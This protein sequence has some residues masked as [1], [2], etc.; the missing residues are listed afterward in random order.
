MPVRKNSTAITIIISPISRIIILIPVCPKRFIS[1]EELI[2]TV[3]VTSSISK[4][5]A[6]KTTLSNIVFASSISTIALV[7][8][9][10]PHSIGIANGVIATSFIV[11]FISESLA[12]IGDKRALSISKPTTKK[13]A[14]PTIR[15]LFTEIPNTRKRNCPEKA[16]T[17][18]IINV[19]IT[20]RFAMASLSFE[21]IS[22]VSPKKTGIALIGL[23]NVKKDVKTSNPYVS[24]SFIIFSAKI[25]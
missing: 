21:S 7:I 15:K 2:R 25:Y 9:P 13:I 11:C 16:N 1:F 22:E 24:I 8:A 5:D 19:T 14:P 3:Y 12:L 23:I 17:N 20:A 10:G 6:T 18:N 4:R